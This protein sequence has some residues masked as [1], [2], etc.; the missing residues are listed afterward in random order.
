MTRLFFFNGK[1]VLILCWLN[2]QDVMC[3]AASTQIH[4]AVV[5][6]LLA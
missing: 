2:H 3:V 6:M 1:F 4:L 5:F